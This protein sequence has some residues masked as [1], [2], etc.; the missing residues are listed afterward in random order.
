MAQAYGANQYSRL[1]RIGYAANGVVVVWMIV[2]T[3]GLLITGRAIAQLFVTDIRV[4][5]LASTLFIVVGIMQVCDGVQ[6]VSLGALRGI[7]DSR[8]A[9]IATLFKHL[10]FDGPMIL[11]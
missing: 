9:T 1:R 3:V 11:R 5:E 6:S 10:K 8:W 4:I 7:L 2:F